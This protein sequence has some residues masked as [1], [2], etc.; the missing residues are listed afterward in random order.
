M[1]G[2]TVRTVFDLRLIASS[3]DRIEQWAQHSSAAGYLIPATS[4]SAAE[5]LSSY[6]QSFA[7]SPVR[8]IHHAPYVLIHVS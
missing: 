3:T 6:L 5:G 2:R 8:T 1:P 4:I 7:F